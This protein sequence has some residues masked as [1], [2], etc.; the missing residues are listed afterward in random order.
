M[1][2]IG[3]VLH[4]TK[5]GNLVTTVDHMIKENTT[6]YLKR[7]KILGIVIE[8]FGPVAEPYLLIKPVILNANS[9]DDIYTVK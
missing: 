8:T 5:N 6:V 2:K 4:Y 9:N 7:G 1:K 3:K